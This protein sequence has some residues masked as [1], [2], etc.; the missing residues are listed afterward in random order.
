MTSPPTHEDARPYMNRI[1][2]HAI[3]WWEAQRPRD[4]TLMDHL[5]DP[6]V[7]CRTPREQELASAVAAYL[8]PR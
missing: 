1:L 7:N 2:T 6:A 8:H 3:A 4:W 5:A